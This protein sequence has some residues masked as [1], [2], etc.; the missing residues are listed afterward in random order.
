MGD[1]LIGEPWFSMRNARIS[2]RTALRILG[3]F[4]RPLSKTRGRA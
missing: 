2:E 4:L 3:D 1:I